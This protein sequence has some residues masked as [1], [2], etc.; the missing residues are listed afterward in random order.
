MNWRPGKCSGRDLVGDMIAALKRYGI[1]IL[2]YTHPGDSFAN[3]T[4]A[5]YS[6]NETIYSVGKDLESAGLGTY[7]AYDLAPDFKRARG[8]YADD[9]IAIATNSQD[10]VRA[11]LVLDALKA[12]PEVNNL[13]IGGIQGKHFDLDEEG[14]RV[15]LEG[16]AGYPWNAWSWALQRY[17]QPQ[18]A[19]MDPRQKEF[20]A[21]CD[22]NEYVPE[23]TGFTFDKSA[24]ETELNVINSIRDEYKY[25]FT[26]GVYGDNTAA[27]FEEFKGKLEAAGLEKVTEEFKAQYK[28]YCEGKGIAL[29]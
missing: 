18:D 1:E 4:S 28:A 14:N 10:P 9:A 26:L 2:L 6:Y 27:K 12:F 13:I 11:A 29:E 25:S 21:I 19:T 23:F 8:S 16:S 5:S 24:V 17:D 7:E 22:A 15:V 3:G 20:L